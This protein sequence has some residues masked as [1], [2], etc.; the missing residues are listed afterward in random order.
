MFVSP[1]QGV[2]VAAPT[3]PGH[4]SVV[5]LVGAIAYFFELGSEELMLGQIE[6]QLSSGR[7]K[8]ILLNFPNNPTGKMVSGDFCGVSRRSPRDTM[9]CYQ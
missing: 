5:S 8:V 1:G 4:L 3:Y 7:I 9:R 6:M 2:L